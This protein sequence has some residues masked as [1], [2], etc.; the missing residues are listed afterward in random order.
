MERTCASFACRRFMQTW[1]LLLRTRFFFQLQFAKTYFVDDLTPRRTR[2]KLRLA[3][4]KSI[5]RSWPCQT[6]MKL[7]W[8]KEVALYRVVRRNASTSPEQFS[9]MLRFFCSTRR[10]PVSI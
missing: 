9:R 5:M 8:D 6:D 2:L 1:R 3:P 10:R 7:W 4:R